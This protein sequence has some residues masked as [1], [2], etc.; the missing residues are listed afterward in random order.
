MRI[1][2]RAADRRSSTQ[3]TATSPAPPFAGDG[4]P[5]SERATFAAGCFWGIEA[6]FR[7]I[8]GVTQTAVG[9]TGGST[10]APTYEQ[11][12]AHT[13]GHAEAVEV[14]FDPDRVS[15]EQLLE[16]FWTVHNPTTRNRQGLDIGS[17]Y[18]SAI[19]THSPGQEAAAKASRE[20]E[21]THRRKRIVTEIVPASAFYR[22]EE[23]HQRYFEKTGRASCALSVN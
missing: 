21:Q 3:S 23:Y 12:S 20:R 7:E 10:P 22:A 18:R 13:T 17:Q 1:F 4:P 2:H 6:L 16:R 5:G 9:Y 19:F 15:Y 8:E 14:W 11:V